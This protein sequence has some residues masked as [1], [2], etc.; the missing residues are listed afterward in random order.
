MPLT[1][2]RAG[3]AA[4]A[5]LIRIIQMNPDPRLPVLQDRGMNRSTHPVQ[6]YFETKDSSGK[7]FRCADDK[8]VMVDSQHELYARKGKAAQAQK[9]LEGIGSSIELT[10]LS[11]QKTV[12]GL[13]VNLHKVRAG[14]KKNKTRGDDMKLYADCGKACKEV[15]GSQSPVGLYKL[16]GSARPISTTGATLPG[17]KYAKGNPAGMKIEIMVHLLAL[18]YR[19]KIPAGTKS[20]IKRDFDDARRLHRMLVKYVD[21]YDR[22]KI[23]SLTLYWFLLKKLADIYM[24]IYNRMK[25]RDR[26]LYDKDLGINK[27]ANPNAGQGYTISTGGKGKSQWPF[28]WAGVIMTSDDNA[29]KVT[30]ENYSINE[31]NREN[32]AWK[33]KMYGTKKKG[34]T[35]H[36]QHLATGT[37]NDRPTTMVVKGSQ[38]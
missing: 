22:K 7:P 37:Y 17:M 34:Q 15:I 29:D 30:L 31:V 14:N 8:S 10:E 28:H 20:A 5:R 35:F 3:T 21:G 33:F 13:S 38:N 26:N 16:P 11:S 1:D 4:Q 6:G 32:K 12:K 2:N 36:E 19:S 18:L 23:K 25:E 27:H 24:R 9:V